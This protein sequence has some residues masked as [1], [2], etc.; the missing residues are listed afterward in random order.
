[1]G[2]RGRLENMFD[3]EELKE[4]NSKIDLFFLTNIAKES[5]LIGLSLIHI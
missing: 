3:I 2:I 1:M 5:A 4:I